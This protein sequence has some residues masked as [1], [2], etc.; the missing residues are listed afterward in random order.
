MNF[1]VANIIF[2][3]FK[4]LRIIATQTA[5]TNRQL[6]Q[7]LRI[8]VL[9]G[10]P[11]YLRMAGVVFILCAAAHKFTKAYLDISNCL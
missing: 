2:H 9:F 3:Y 7:Q 5:A 11:L 8:H 1:L 6:L 4:I 10:R